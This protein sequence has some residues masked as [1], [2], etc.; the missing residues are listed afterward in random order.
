MA[1]HKC[2]ECIYAGRPPAARSLISLNAGWPAM[3]A[4]VNHP[5]A[6]GELRDVLPSADACRNFRLRPEPP[7][8][9]APPPPPKKGLRYIALTKGK[10]ALVDAADYEWLSQYRWHATGMHGRYYAATVINKKAVT[11]HRMILNPPPGKVADHHDGN[12]LNNSRTNLRNCTRQQNRHNTRPTGKTSQY[13]GVTRRG[14][15]WIA[16]IT[17]KKKCHFLGPFDTEIEAAK[18]RD[19]KALQLHGEYAWLNFPDETT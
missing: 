19:K 7:V 11:M 3:L 14:Q 8:R 5:E 15:K 13:I 10:F 18:A 6:P 9:L 1:R 12:G 2:H 17:H 16:K 4:C